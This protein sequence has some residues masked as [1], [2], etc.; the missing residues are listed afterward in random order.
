MQWNASNVPGWVD[1]KAL[2]LWTEYF[3]DNSCD[4]CSQ[5]VLE[6]VEKGVIIR[7]HQISIDPMNSLD[8]LGAYEI[9]VQIRS[10]YINP[11]PSQNP[12]YLPW[13]RLREN[14]EEVSAG[15]LH[16]GDRSLGEE[17]PGDPLMAY[18]VVIIMEGTGE[19]HE[20]QN[21]IPLNDTR[22]I[23]GTSQI[24]ASLGYLPE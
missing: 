9:G 6:D 17:V 20:G 2:R 24:E 13:A 18:R 15:M 10:R 4:P 11:S 14:G 3:V 1:Q 19:R 12:E 7:T 23:L 5:R 22:L 21:W 8:R 16:L